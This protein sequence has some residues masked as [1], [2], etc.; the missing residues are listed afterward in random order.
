MCHLCLQ[1]GDIQ[2]D[3]IGAEQPG[4]ALL[5]AQRP[6]WT[7]EQ[8]ID[9]LQSGLHFSDDIIQY[10]F[11]KNAN[12]WVG[13]DGQGEAAGHS[14][15]NGFQKSQSRVAFEL[16]DDL[17]AADL[18]ET[19]NVGKSDITISNT[20]TGI[21]YAHGWFPPIGA[22]W[23]H[24][25]EVQLQKP[26]LGEFGFLTLLHEIGHTLGLHHSQT[27]ATDSHAYSVMSYRPATESGADISGADTKLYFPQTPMIHDIAAIQRAY[28]ADMTTRAGDTVYGFNSNTNSPIFD[29][30]QNTNPIL[31]I[32]DAGGVDTLDLS[33]FAPGAGNAGSVINLAPG[34]FSDTA[35]MTKNIS[36]AFGAWIENAIGGR[37]ND[38]I[39]GNEMANRLVGNA[40]DDIL[41]GE[42]GNDHLDGGAGRDQLFGGAGNDILIYD[43]ADGPSGADGGTGIDILQIRG[44]QVPTLDLTGSRIEFAD[45]IQTDTLDAASWSMKTDRYNADWQRLSQ[46]GK[47]DNGTSWKTTW[48]H[49]DAQSWILH[50]DHFDAAGR[51]VQQTGEFDNGQTWEHAWNFA[52]EAEWAYATTL[53]DL[54]DLTWW[55]ETTKQFDAQGRTIAQFGTND[56]GHTWN[57]MFD[58]ENTETWT[59]QSYTYDVE[60]RNY[61]RSGEHDTG[62]SWREHFD[63]GDDYWWTDH[64]NTYTAIGH[65]VSQIGKKDNGQTWVHTWDVDE[66]EVWSRKTVSEDISDLTW[67]QSHVLYLNDAGETY[68]QTGVKDSGDVWEHVWDVEGTEV[69]HRQTQI[70]DVQDLHAWSEQIQTFDQSGRVLSTFYVDDIA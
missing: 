51:R 41:Q 25:D 30:A 43:D 1:F 56:N 27:H 4:D 10:A 23:L 67:W 42:E 69:W 22:A 11:P 57:H 48:D 61:L 64:L 12:F 58:V 19:D 6:V 7:L 62:A 32:W 17:I 54:S 31:A 45:H 53:L 59:R 50:T 29:F 28:G 2:R 65:K 46:T 44:G 3:P 8:I 20:T 37:G 70:Y 60:G 5:L 9:Q 39:T 63:V 13:F 34:S 16:W 68:R 24:T 47:N 26:Q 52:Q 55:N 38:S 49:N 15:L 35:S 33:G 18:V 36:I 21:G 14:P 66:T 40:G